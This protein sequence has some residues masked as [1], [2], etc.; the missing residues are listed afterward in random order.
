MLRNLIL[1]LSIVTT[2]ALVLS[3][4]VFDSP[5]DSPLMKQLRAN[6]QARLKTL[7]DYVK[8]GQFPF[9]VDKAQAIESEDPH[10]N[11][12]HPRA[13]RFRGNNGK[14]CALA[15]LINTAGQTSIVERVVKS[16]NHYCVGKD[17][18]LEID[19]WIEKS[20]LTVEECISIQAPSDVPAT[21][22]DLEVRLSPQ[23]TQQRRLRE[24]L[25][26]VIVKLEARTESSLQE[27]V[28]QI[29]ANSKS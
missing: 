7:K 18:N 5:P 3:I 9:G 14:L 26:A 27:I 11:N 20:G 25:E 12:Q 22:L 6:R 1:G 2:S 15:Y 24:S 29:Q 4:T 8:R 10:F 13:H 21:K 23:E 19:K 17:Q 28:S 16:D